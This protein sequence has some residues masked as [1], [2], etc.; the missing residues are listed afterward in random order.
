[1]RISYL[2]S[3]LDAVAVTLDNLYSRRGVAKTWPQGRSD[4]FS[5]QQ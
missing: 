2:T 4:V 3:G 1:M 5:K